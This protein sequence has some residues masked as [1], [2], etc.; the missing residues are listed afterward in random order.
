M[1]LT[2]AER[3]RKALAAVNR[4]DIDAA[5]EHVQPDVEWRPPGILPDVETYYG[6]DG[7]REW[8]ATMT[9]AFEDLRVDPTGDFTELDD[10]HVLVPVRSSAR[11]RE[12]GVRVDAAMYLLGTGRE[13]LER[14]E[15]FPTEEEAL[16]A[17]G[18][19]M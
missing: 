1:G 2:N 4:G 16:E 17:A 15:F 13:L 5:L 7:V 14:M 18:H 6:H 12:S 8:M 10:V 19:K 11:G 3:F 9:E